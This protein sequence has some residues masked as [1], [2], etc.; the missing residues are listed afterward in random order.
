MTP[1]TDKSPDESLPGLPQEVRR[2][3]LLSWASLATERLYPIVWPAGG[4]VAF[5]IVLALANVFV[6]LPEWLH[7]LVLT[8]FL[9]AIGWSIAWSS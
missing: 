8:G 3:V 2:H 1:E 7:L 9:G 6:Y 4:F 5:F